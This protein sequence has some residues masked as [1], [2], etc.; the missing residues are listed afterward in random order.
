ML[1][2]LGISTDG[3][4]M[5]APSLHLCVDGRYI[6][7]RYPGIGRVTSML[8][9]VWSTH[10]H[11]RRLDIIVNPD[12]P[13]HFFELPEID[14]H[15]HIHRLSATPFGIKEWWQMCG[16]MR[17]LRPDWIYAPYFLMPP[18][19]AP[20]K[21]LLTIHDAIPLEL[22]S[23]SVIRQHV[24]RQ[25]VKFSMARA[26]SVTTVSAYAAQQIQHHYAYRGPIAVIPNGIN[27]LFFGAPV[28]RNL[29]T[30]G[31]IQP[32]G[33]C[34]SSNQPHK[35]LDGL[36]HAWSHAYRTGQIPRHSQ[37]VLAGHVDARR[38]LPWHDPRYADIPVIHIP[39]PDDE[40][41]N[42]LYHA[43]HL[44]ILPSLAEGFGLP[45]LEALAAGRVVLCH[46]Y[47]TLRE[48]HGDVV[49]YADMRHPQ[50]VADKLSALWHDHAV[51]Q[52]FSAQAEAHAQTFR[53][54]VIADRY[55]A[56]M[57]PH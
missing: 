54:D 4:A 26:D 1:V 38:P 55:I 34:V 5:D 6:I 13:R 53:W 2:L 48:L 47:P 27:E 28:A 44:F 29:A 31:I 51:R 15:V 42:Q 43:A 40:L 17:T 49:A 7:N 56:Y 45:I 50:R 24:L 14:G 57:H 41:L 23:M 19:H 18:R 32:F 8:C 21:R 37:L 36:M 22:R 20:T 16:L 10:P 3:I 30:H 46:D 35:N 39:D 9:Q 52:K 33:L 12:S 25:L 11:I